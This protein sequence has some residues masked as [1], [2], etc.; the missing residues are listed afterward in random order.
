MSSKI[1]RIQFVTDLVLNSQ[2]IT[3]GNIL[4]MPIEGKG[5]Y[6]MKFRKFSQMINRSL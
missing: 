6:L 4:S 5:S 2:Y 1:F 3:S